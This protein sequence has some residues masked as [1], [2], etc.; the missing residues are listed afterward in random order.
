MTKKESAI[1]RGIQRHSITSPRA[2]SLGVIAFNQL[3]R[4]D[5]IV[6]IVNLSIVGVGIESTEKIEPG[7][8][9]FKES[10]GGHKFGVLT[11]IKR[12]EDRYRGG[13]NF[14]TLSLDK[15]QYIQEQIRQS[16]PH[17]S[18][19]DPENIIASLLDSIKQDT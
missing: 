9:C 19:S 13:I 3:K 15:E 11:W 17:R 2:C 14:V 12:S 8:V 6:Q 18:V 4:T 1:Q 5:H 10:V 7:L 16:R